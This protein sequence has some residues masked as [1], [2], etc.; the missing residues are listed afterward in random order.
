M[1]CLCISRLKKERPPAGRSGT[2][3]PADEFDLEDFAD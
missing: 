3:D 2:W 1:V